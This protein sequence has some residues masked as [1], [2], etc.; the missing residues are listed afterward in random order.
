M[1]RLIENLYK[2]LHSEKFPHKRFSSNLGNLNF[3]VVDCVEAGDAQFDLTSKSLQCQVVYLD[4][5]SSNNFV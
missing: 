2:E 5:R 4:S 3:N 1:N